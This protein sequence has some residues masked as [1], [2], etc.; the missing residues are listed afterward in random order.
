MAEPSVGGGAG[1]RVVAEGGR[2][3]RY[4]GVIESVN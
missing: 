1:A 2:C 3:V 4:K